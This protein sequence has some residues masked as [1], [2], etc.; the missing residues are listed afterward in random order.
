MAKSWVG[1]TVV[2]LIILGLRLYFAFQTPYYSS[3]TSYLHVRATETILEGKILWQDPLGYGGRTLVMS[4]LFDAILA[5]FTLFM[6]LSLVFKLIP[7]IFA[8]LLVIPAFLISY[9]LSQKNWVA[10]FAAFFASIIPAYLSNT[11]NHITPLTLAIPIFFFLAYAWLQTPKRAW[12]ITFLSLLLVFVFL[13]PLSIVFV[14]SIGAYIILS[15]LEHLKPTNAEYELGLFSLFFALWAQFLL[16]KKLI[17]FHGPSVIWQ[18]IPK[19]MLSAFYSNIT[20]FDAIWQIGLVPLTG[21]TYALY[22]TAF[23]TQQK[24]TQLL[25]AIT[26]VSTITLWFKL[27]D[28]TTGFILLGI[29]LALLFSQRIILFTSFISETKISKYGP[30]L[31]ILILLSALSTV[32]YPAYAETKEQLSHTITQEEITALET[33]SQE[34]PEDATI[35]APANYGNY[36]TAIAKRKNAID[37]YFLLRPRI[38]ERYQDI[39]RLY[40]T[41]FQTEAVELFDKYEANYI[42]VPPSYKDIAYGNSQCFTRIQATNI[43]VY[44]KNPECKV[45]VVA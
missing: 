41:T 43:Q 13:H 34:T 4:P 32:V 40:K 11:F 16:Y 44:E 33:L 30:A 27:I 38:N 35:I 25:L 3:D 37:E 28:V 24:E 6:P 20:I 12:I 7:N 1:L 21:G 29:T 26:I 9:K 19:E 31:T 45:R 23:K 39:T 18:N 5:F 42:I 14:L 36:I 17:L 22:K 10:L 2:F 8:S 15:S